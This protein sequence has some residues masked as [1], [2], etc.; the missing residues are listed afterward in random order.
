ML[1][2]VGGIPYLVENATPSLP[3][4][5]YKIAFLNTAPISSRENACHCRRI[6]RSHAAH[7]T[8]RIFL[9]SLHPR[10]TGYTVANT[11]VKFPVNHFCRYLTLCL[12]HFYFALDDKTKTLLRYDFDGRHFLLFIIIIIFVHFFIFVL[13]SVFYIIHAKPMKNGKPLEYYFASRKIKG[14]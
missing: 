6:L 8:L 11:R 14:Y 3:P 1:K 10:S 12:L 5:K 4:P 13:S 9:F 7:I 2:G